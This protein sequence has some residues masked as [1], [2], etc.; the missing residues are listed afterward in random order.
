MKTNRNGLWAL[1]FA[2]LAVT[3][4]AAPQA[5]V[6]VRLAD[7][8]EEALLAAAARIEASWSHTS[9]LVSATGASGA[10]VPAAPATFPMDEI[11]ESLAGVV[12]L[13]WHGEL[14]PAVKSLAT[15]A[16]Y[17]F[18]EIGIPAGGP[19]LVSLSAKAV[20]VGEL[21][22][23]AGNQAGDRADVVVR[24]V[25]RRIEVVYRDVERR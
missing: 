12:D 1:A 7:P 25:S 4:C 19:I 13:E 5:R 14:A 2:A 11:P 24:P 21:L 17:Q 20:P 22:R 9:S 8:A 3:G 18:E 10:E 6:D 15:L 23:R 16:G